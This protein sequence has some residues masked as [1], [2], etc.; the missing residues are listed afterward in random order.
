MTVLENSIRIQA[1]PEKVWLVLGKLDALEP[2]R[3]RS[4]NGTPGRWTSRAGRSPGW[5]T[6][7][8]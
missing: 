4:R 1:P 2:A 7:P 6:S 5:C 8:P 3:T